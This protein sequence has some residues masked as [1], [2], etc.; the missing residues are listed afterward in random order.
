MIPPD[1]TVF[2]VSVP[3]APELYTGLGDGAPARALL[4]PR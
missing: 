4:I 3:I 1:E 2:A